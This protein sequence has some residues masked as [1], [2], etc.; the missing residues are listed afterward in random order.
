MADMCPILSHFSSYT[1]SL[2][3]L[4]CPHETRRDAILELATEALQGKESFGSN[5]TLSAVRT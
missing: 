1:V 5:T 4:F 2:L 3:S